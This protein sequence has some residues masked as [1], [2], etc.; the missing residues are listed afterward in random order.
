MSG[1]AVDSLLHRLR[2]HRE[3][4]QPSE[5]SARFLVTKISWRGSYRRLLVITPSALVTLYPDSLAATNSWSFGDDGDIAG[6]DLAGDHAEGEVIVVRFRRDRRGLP[7]ETRFACRDR[8]AVLAALLRSVATLASRGMARELAASLLPPTQIFEA[9]KLRRNGTWVKTTLRVTPI[10]TERVD[11]GS[12]V[13]RWRLEHRH[14][15]SPAARVLSSADAQA[16]ELS[17]AL[18][19]RVGGSPRVFSSRSRDALLRAAQAAALRCLGLE[20]A[21][22]A[23]GAAQQLAGRQLLA[24]VAGAERERAARPEEAPL[25]EWEVLK[26]RDVG[27]GDAYADLTASSHSV[28]SLFGPFPNLY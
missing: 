26:A 12:G 28:S 6:I 11:P 21:I 5:G 25:G 7:K 22:D 2:S 4:F 23:G 14:A 19:G 27:A 13:I 16:G 18:F 24:A 8:A 1:A 15:A 9:H 3:R 20:L 17:F 10:A